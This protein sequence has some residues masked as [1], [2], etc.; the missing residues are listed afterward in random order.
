MALPRSSF[1]NSLLRAAISSREKVRGS[2]NKNVTFESLSYNI[3]KI[4]SNWFTQCFG[5]LRWHIRKKKGKAK[6]RNS[7]QN[8][9][10]CMVPE[11]LN[12]NSARKKKLV[13]VAFTLF[14]TV[15]GCH[16]IKKFR[17]WVN[18]LP[19]NAVVFSFRYRNL[20]DKSNCCVQVFKQISVRLLEALFFTPLSCLTLSRRFD[21]PIMWMP[22]TKP[23]PPS[24][25]YTSLST[26]MHVKFA[27][28]NFLSLIV[29][30]TL[31]HATC[32]SGEA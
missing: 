20:V 17:N 8:L 12:Q 1:L 15:E 21:E 25:K 32:D 10:I 29:A 4:M 11:V 13:L 7:S 31:W 9:E 26:N 23:S 3:I 24:F 14:H 30:H 19:R 28:G 6:R 22:S 18:L 5:Y 27:I 16:I 2:E